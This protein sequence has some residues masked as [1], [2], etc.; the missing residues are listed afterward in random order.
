MRLGDDQ[1]EREFAQWQLNVGHGMHTDEDAN[2]TIPEQ[3]HCSSNTV[4]ALV[5]E[6]Y[7]GIKE[8]PHPP[9]EYFSKRSILSA[10]NDSVDSLNAK[11]LQDFPGQEKTFHGT[12][13]NI[14]MYPVEYLNFI[15]VKVE[16]QTGMSCDG[17]AKS[18]SY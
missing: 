16:A 2:I 7:P 12:E 18:K 9:D 13:E 3:F 5:D 14:L 15:N 10:R 11:I 1:E 17:V 6:I 4:D 8:L